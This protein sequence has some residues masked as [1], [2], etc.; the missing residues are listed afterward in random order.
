MKSKS[1]EKTRKNA[2]T[3][4]TR[5]FAKDDEIGKIP[6]FCLPFVSNLTGA[7]KVIQSKYYDYLVMSTLISY[8]YK[9]V[10]KSTIRHGVV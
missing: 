1:K 4:E 8:V 6:K 9:S 3:K 2:S 10:M 7:I 5:V